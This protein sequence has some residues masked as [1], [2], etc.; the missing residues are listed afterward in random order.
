MEKTGQRLRSLKVHA[1]IMLTG[2]IAQ[3]IFGTDT[4]TMF[5]VPAGCAMLCITNS[6]NLSREA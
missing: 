5:A 4:T 6:V 3:Y 2:G 1:I